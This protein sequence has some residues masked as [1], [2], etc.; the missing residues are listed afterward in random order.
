MSLCQ[1]WE[2]CG[3]STNSLKNSNGNLLFV[4]LSGVDSVAPTPPPPP[5]EQH[6]FKDLFDSSCL[7]LVIH[8]NNR[9]NF[10][11]H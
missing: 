9:I 3:H 6:F 1:N 8:K 4:I 11:G 2:F 7:F 10:N 5:F